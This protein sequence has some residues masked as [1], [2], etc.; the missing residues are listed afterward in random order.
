M[1]NKINS[2]RKYIFCFIEGDYAGTGELTINE[3]FFPSVDFEY[4]YAMQDEI[5]KIL[6][7]K[8]GEKLPLKFNRDYKDSDGFIKRIQ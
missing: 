8:K 6:D 3:I 2:L 4:I 5:D 7:L 1:E